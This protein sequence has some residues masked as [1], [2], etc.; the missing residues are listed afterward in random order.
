MRIQIEKSQIE[1]TPTWH[2]FGGIKNWFRP[3]PEAQRAAHHLEN[4][5]AS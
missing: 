4:H 5:N 2:N 3:K 1:I